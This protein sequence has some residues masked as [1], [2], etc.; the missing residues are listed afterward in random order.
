MAG[1]LRRLCAGWVGRHTS[2][3]EPLRGQ[4]CKLELC[5]ISRQVEIPS[6]TECGKNVQDDDLLFV[7]HWISTD[8]FVKKNICCMKKMPECGIWTPTS[9]VK[10]VTGESTTDA[11]LLSPFLVIT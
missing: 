6:W 7:Q 5:K 10:V 8:I 11:R 1:R 4:T 9:G 3:I 2:I